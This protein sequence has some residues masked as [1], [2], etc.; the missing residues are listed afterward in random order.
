[1]KILLAGWFSF[2]E[3]GAT[4]G[5]LLSRD[6]ACEWLGLAGVPY[7]IAIA[8]PFSGGVDWR[9]VDPRSYSHIVFVCGPFGNGWLIGEFLRRFAA[10]R[11][12]GL[13]LSMIDPLETWNPFEL[14][15]ERDSSACAR[16][17]ISFLSRQSR[18]PVVGVVLV[19]PQIEYRGGMHEAVN[20]AIQRLVASR[21]MAVV[22]ID[23]RLDVNSTGLRSPSEVE[24]LIS[25]LD[26]VLTTRLHG[27]VLG[28]KNGVPVVAIDPIAGGAK[29]RRQ[30]ESIGWPVVFVPDDLTDEALTKAFEYCLTDE[31]RAKARES[32]TRATRI[33]VETREAFIA[34]LTR[35][36]V[37]AKDQTRG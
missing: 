8:P 33:V 6:L 14:L 2:E 36:D 35:L 4:A 15:L 30:A 19:H 1:M 11:L 13:N 31:A 5:D 10:C 21:E 34:A 37:M 29:I 7:D 3:M 9:S 16:P 23:T 32:A 28:V 17:D 22:R 27:L 20:N 18:V 12:V 25:R 26:V 24:S